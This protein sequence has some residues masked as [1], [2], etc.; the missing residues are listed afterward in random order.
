MTASR[1]LTNRTNKF[2]LATWIVAVA[3]PLA[4]AQGADY[5]IVFTSPDTLRDLGIAVSFG[6]RAE[7][8]ENKCYYYGDGGYLISISD[9]FL[10]RFTRKGFSVEAACLGLISNS[11]YDPETGHRLPTY[12]IADREMIEQGGEEPG[13]ATEELPLDLPACFKN[14]NPYT[15]CVFRYGRISGKPLSDAE[16]ETYRDLGSAFDAAMRD[17]LQRGEVE[18]P[19]VESGSDDGEFRTSGGYF[20][21][22]LFPNIDD[23]LLRYSSAS[24]WVV[25]P[26]LKRGY[27]YALDADGGAGPSVSEAALSEA[28]DGLGKPQLSVDELQRALDE[29]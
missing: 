22:E 26:N 13:A 28:I 7:P 10:G 1:R 25:N 17:A 5:P 29:E 4:T 15:D 27:G 12:I 11:R 18:G 14:A 16:T 8:L 24:V 2:G 6:Q 9:E 20:L 23:K 19:S 3:L 21:P